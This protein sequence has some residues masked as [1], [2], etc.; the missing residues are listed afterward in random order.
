MSQMGDDGVIPSHVDPPLLEPLLVTTT[1]IDESV[2]ADQTKGASATTTTS[3]T[4]GRGG[5][6]VT[7]LHGKSLD[8]RH[9]FPGGIFFANNS[10]APTS[11]ADDHRNASTTTRRGIN[12]NNTQINST[13]YY[14]QRHNRRITQQSSISS[15]KSTPYILKLL[16]PP[17]LITNHIL[18][19]HAQ[20][21]PMW[22]LAYKINVSIVATANSL[23][24]KAAAD[25]L[26]VP[27]SYEYKN[28]TQEN[29]IVETF[30]YMDAIRKL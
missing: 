11:A 19:Y 8:L 6:G 29:N 17:L 25:A 21:K 24:S 7:T 28:T 18:F 16:V 5:G 2:A 14:K 12:N 22:N 20:T 27:H 9:L 15:S 13:K 26:N 1:G 30:T 4:V 3:A 23:K 10:T